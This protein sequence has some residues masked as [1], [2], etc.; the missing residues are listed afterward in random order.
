MVKEGSFRED[1]YYRICEMEISIPPLRARKGDKSLLARH[2]LNKFSHQQNI[3]ARGFSPDA[4][5]AIEA[6]DW[7]G[8]IREL[9][10]KIKRSVIMCDGKSISVEDMG[11]AEAETLSLNL[12]QVR[13]EAE[14]AAISHALILT[15]SNISATAKLLGVTRPTLY[16]LM[17]KY[18]IQESSH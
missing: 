8:N 2:F 14:H 17:K 18:N 9:E 5:S 1:L 3:N 11:L 12:R 4:D 15:D 7:P 6:Y 13:Q 16:D 10:N